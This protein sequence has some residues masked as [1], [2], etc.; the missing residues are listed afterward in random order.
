MRP[1]HQLEIKVGL[2]VLAGVIGTCTL[3]LTADKIRIERTYTVTAYLQDAGG[4]REE[5]PVT[6][7]GIAVGK[8]QGIEFVAPGAVAPGKVRATVTIAQGVVLPFDAEAQLATSG[9]F[10]DASLALAA[11]K[12]PSGALLP[13]DGSGTLVVQPGFL[14]QAADKAGGILTAVEDLLDAQ[15]RSDA[16]RL[17][18][19]AADLAGHA[20]SIAARLD[21]QQDRI[22]TILANL[23]QVTTELKTTTATLNARLDPLLVKIDATMDKAGRLADSGTTAVESVDAL[24]VRADGLIADNQ[25]RLAQLLTSVSGAAAKAQRIAAVLEGGQG[26]LGQLLVNRDLAKD[27]QTVSVDLAAAATQVAD[28]PSRL[29]F[30]ASDTEVQR[31][32]AKRNREKMRRTLAEGLGEPAPVEQAKHDPASDPAMSAPAAK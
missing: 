13:T 2:L 17:V 19:G 3:V 24:V 15:T 23:E 22:G 9:V 16:K 7:S 31:A 28:Q 1:V 29:V 4:L 12:K 8:V 20:A 14:D 26:V 25:E 10:G 27:L 32:Q 5:S 6:L 30:D 11:P 18:S 21:G